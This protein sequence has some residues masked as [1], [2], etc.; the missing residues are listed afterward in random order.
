[1]RGLC[2][3]NPTLRGWFAYFQ[4]SSYPSLDLQGSRS[5]GSACRLRSIAAQTHA[6]VAVEP[7]ALSDHHRWP[8]SLLRRSWAVQSRGSP[9]LGP[10]ILTKVRPSTG[11]PDAGDPQVRFGGRRELNSISPP[12]PY[13]SFAAPSAKM[14]TTAT[15]PN[16]NLTS[17][18]CSDRNKIWGS[19]RADGAA[20]LR[21]FAAPS[22]KMASTAI[23]PIKT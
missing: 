14:G 15:T 12:Y 21:S 10:S 7:E 5:V 20:R 17:H 16:Q 2:E 9:C 22:A 1:V 3:L 13:R 19:M 23:P 8:K 4:H 6:V 11:E 18:Q